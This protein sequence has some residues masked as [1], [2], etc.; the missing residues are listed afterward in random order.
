M[1]LPRGDRATEQAKPAMARLDD[2]SEKLLQAHY[3]A[4]SMDL[5]RRE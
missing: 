2:Q 5:L 3:N 1:V 4:I